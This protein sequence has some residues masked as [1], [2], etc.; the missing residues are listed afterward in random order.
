MAKI[1]WDISGE[2]GFAIVS[3]GGSA[4][5]QLVGVKTLLYNGRTD[6]GNC[7]VVGEYRQQSSS[8]NCRGMLVLR[9]DADMSNCYRLV[10]FGPRLYYVQKAVDGTVT[11]LATLNSTQSWD[12]Y[13]PTR[14]RADGFQLSVD[15]Y[16]GGEWVNVI[17]V[18]DN[19]SSHIAG[20]VGIGGVSVA[21]YHG[22]FDNVTLGERQV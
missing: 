14:F 4:R 1:N 6:F 10:I 22:L 19:E 17:T 13:L 9:S 18:L 7:E 21:G 2:G 11:T 15:E 3:M 16:A 20:R 8:S 5:C 12:I